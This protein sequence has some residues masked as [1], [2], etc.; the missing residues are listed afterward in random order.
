MTKNNANGY[1][2]RRRHSTDQ[3][4]ACSEFELRIAALEDNDALFDTRLTNM[5]TTINEV[6]EEVVEIKSKVTALTSRMDK[7]EELHSGHK[8][9]L[10]ELHGVLTEVRELL[11]TWN[12]VKATV[13]LTKTLGDAVMWI[14]KAG[15]AGAVMWAAFKFA[16][17]KGN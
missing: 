7:S 6:K 15:A 10:E 1:Q 14:A 12:S 9:V 2:E 3:G 11:R 5:D 16:V 4:C 17:T 13:M 8:Q